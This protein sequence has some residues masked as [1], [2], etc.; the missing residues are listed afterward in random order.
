MRPL[1]NAGATCPEAPLRCNLDSERPLASLPIRAQLFQSLPRSS[2]RVGLLTL[3]YWVGDVT[4]SSLLQGPLS[5]RAFVEC[6]FFLSSPSLLMGTNGSEAGH[7]PRK[8]P[9]LHDF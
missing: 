7:L 2:A 6:H 1:P 3:A 8:C 9:K 4:A 5:P